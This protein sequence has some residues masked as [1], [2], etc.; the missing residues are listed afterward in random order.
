MVDIGINRSFL[1]LQ[2]INLMLLVG[3]IKLAIVAGHIHITLDVHALDA[4]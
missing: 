1:V 4:N 2:S 3:W